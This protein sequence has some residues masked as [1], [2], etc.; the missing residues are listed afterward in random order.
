M[1][2]LCEETLFL[3]FYTGTIVIFSNQARKQYLRSQLDLFLQQ[4]QQN[5]QTCIHKAE[6]KGYDMTKA[7]PTHP[8]TYHT[9]QLPYL[10][11]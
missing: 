4:T 11:G 2:D 3:W 5:I 10:K 6:W 8:K 9:G 1:A 7:Q